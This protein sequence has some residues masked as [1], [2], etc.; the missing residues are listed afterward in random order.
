MTIFLIILGV[1]LF[2][3]LGYFQSQAE[4]QKQQAE[5]E[6]R[7]EDEYQQLLQDLHAADDNYHRLREEWI[8][9]HEQYADLGKPTYT[10]NYCSYLHGYPWEYPTVHIPYEGIANNPSAEFRRNAVQNAIHDMRDYDLPHPS[11][12]ATF[13]KEARYA[14]IGRRG[15]NPEELRFVKS[16]VDKGLDKIVVTITTTDIEHP[17]LAMFFDRNDRGTVDDLKA[18]INAFRTMK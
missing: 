7:L 12:C 3:A 17:T 9:F 4:K 8:A 6:A 18:S 13:W 11:D 5:Q 16:N 2:L 14:V 15:F 10:V 1:A